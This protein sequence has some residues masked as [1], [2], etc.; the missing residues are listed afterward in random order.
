MFSWRDI[1][2]VI[3]DMD[4]TLLDLGMDN[5]LWYG[6]L[7]SRYAERHALTIDAAER[8]VR[9][10][11]ERR[12]GTLA[13]YCFE[14]WSEEFGLD[15]GALECELETHIRPR[16][17]ALD[18]LAWLNARAV[19]VV[20][21]TNAHPSSLKRKL[22]VTGIARY[23]DH[24]V[25]AHEL[26]AAKEQAEFWV[27]LEKRVGYARERCL[28]IDDSAPVRASARRHGIRWIFGI[29]RPD[30]AGPEVIA[31]DAIMI[32][33]FTDLYAGAEQSSGA[34]MTS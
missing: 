15:L 22:G 13:W 2:C 11:L 3:L 24:I 16:Q 19:C 9:A 20:L 14:T 27:R 28:F 10:R 34:A 29:A 23:F 5:R 32:G 21:A 30:S 25:S 26:C 31:D 18:F 6:L 4:G 12:R 33:D 1:D 17:G 7:P 8:E